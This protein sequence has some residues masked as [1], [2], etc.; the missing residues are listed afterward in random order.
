[1]AVGSIQFQLAWLESEF[2]EELKR[3]ARDD[4]NCND[5]YGG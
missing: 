3:L 4:D 1:M 2:K 5:Y